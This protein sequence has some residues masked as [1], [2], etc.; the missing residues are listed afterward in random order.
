MSRGEYRQNLHRPPYHP[1]YAISG[2]LSLHP[3]FI[4]EILQDERSTMNDDFKLIETRP[5]Y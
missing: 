5:I 4:L 2:I 1:Y 3:D